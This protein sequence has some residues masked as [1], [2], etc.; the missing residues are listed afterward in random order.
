MNK[1][2]EEARTQKAI[3]SSLEAKLFIHTSDPTLKRVLTTLS[4][5]TNGVDELRFIL[6]ASQVVVVESAEIVTE[7]ASLCSQVD[8]DLQTIVG[9]A[10]ADGVKC[11]RCWHYSPSVGDSTTYKGACG[12][13]AEA[14]A[15]M[16]FPPVT[17][18]QV[19]PAAADTA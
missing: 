10:P 3:G 19:A 13:C 11:E 1:V 6:L 15:L 17:S 12:R 9:L 14:L 16:D 5:V 8:E 7:N 18:E 4:D 2:I